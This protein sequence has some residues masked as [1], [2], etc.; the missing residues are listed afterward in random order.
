MPYLYQQTL[1]TGVTIRASGDPR[2]IVAAAREQI[3]QADSMMP[4]FDV[5]SVE[6]LRELSYWQYRLFGSMFSIFGVIALGLAS[7]GVYGVLSYSVSQRVQEIGVRMALGAERSDVLRLIVGQ[8]MRLTAL[9]VVAGL[10]GAV[11]ITRLIR[12]LLCN[13]TPTDPLSFGTVS[14]FLTLVAVVA[15]YIPAR[16]AMAVDPIVALRND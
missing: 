1:N 8:G 11:A 14:V 16:R 4:V 10:I 2:L 7:I 13:V 3:R 5:S 12:T 9:G 15:S 6:R